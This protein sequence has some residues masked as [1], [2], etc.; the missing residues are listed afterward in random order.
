MEVE[1]SCENS[2]I[3]WFSWQS[4]V[5][6]TNRCLH[7]SSSV[8]ISIASNTIS[9]VQSSKV[10]V[11]SDCN[12]LLD[13]VQMDVDT[14]S[15]SAKFTTARRCL[16]L[17]DDNNS[18]NKSRY[19]LLLFLLQ[20]IQSLTLFFF[21]ISHTHTN[22]SLAWSLRIQSLRAKNRLWRKIR[23][24]I[25]PEFLSLSFKIYLI[26]IQVSYLANVKKKLFF[27][28]LNV[29]IKINNHLFSI[30]LTKH[31]RYFYK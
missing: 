17:D 30:K 8:S 29:P 15:S 5:P 1:R 21:F 28:I 10:S 4:F 25:K 16:G 11:S 6:Q 2:S 18:Y 26:L 20:I 12:K 31:N 24:Q 7:F 13:P 14:D 9:I 23:L 3:H 27:Y 19:I 22:T